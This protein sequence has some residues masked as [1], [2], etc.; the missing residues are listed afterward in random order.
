[1][2]RIESVRSG[3]L[4]TMCFKWG[5]VNSEL[6]WPLHSDSAI[7]IIIFHTSPLRKYAIIT[8]SSGQPCSSMDTTTF[9]AFFL[10][11]SL[12]PPPISL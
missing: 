3:C 5:N 6:W 11:N 9:P 2:E 4:S 12:N 10:L 8:L 7:I 1:M